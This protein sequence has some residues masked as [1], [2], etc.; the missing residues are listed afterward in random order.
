MIFVTVGAQMPFDRLIAAV[1]RWARQGGRRDVFAQIGESA[2]HPS[3]VQYVKHLEP[4]AF[5]R[6]VAEANLIVAH[7]GMGSILTALEVGRPILVM[8]RRG[9]LRETRYDHQVA[10]ATKLAA[11][12]RVNVAMDEQKL[13][14]KLEQLSEIHASQR[15]GPYASTE[16]LDTL[17]EFIV[18]HG[19][20]SN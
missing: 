14:E 6:K 20:V 16:L 12:G 7:A 10:T 8:P 17:R 13:F 3:S 9:D 5:R 1:D 19:R 15:I 18:G 2:Y 11:F 4:Q